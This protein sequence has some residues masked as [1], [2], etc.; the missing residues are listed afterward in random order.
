MS[1]RHV[2]VIAWILKNWCLTGKVLKE[3][4]TVLSLELKGFNIRDFEMDMSI[5]II[6]E[7]WMSLNQ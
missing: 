7:E 2:H 6:D 5:E 4:L 3:A 1:Y